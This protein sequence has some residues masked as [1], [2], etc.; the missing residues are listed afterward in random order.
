MT[1]SPSLVAALRHLLRPLVRLLAAR[2]V[3]YPT[4]A[5]LLKE[6]YVDVADR[7]FRLENNSATDSRVSLL[8]G[9]HRKYVRRGSRAALKPTARALS[10]VPRSSPPR[11]IRVRKE[12]WAARRLARRRRP[13]RARFGI[14]RARARQFR[15][16]PRPERPDRSGRH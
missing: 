3:T 4:L 2:G 11:S 5:E 8:S 10:N 14:G 15:P 6:T 1:L 9:V 16:G 13:P 7:D 12:P